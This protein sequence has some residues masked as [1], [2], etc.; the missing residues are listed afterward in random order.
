M[1]RITKK[2]LV[3]LS[4][5]LAALQGLAWAAWGSK[6][7][8]VFAGILLNAVFVSVVALYSSFAKFGAGGTEA[9][10][11]KWAYRQMQ[12]LA[13]LNATLPLRQ[14]LPFL[15]GMAVLPDF[16][17][18]LAGLIREIRPRRILELGSGA[19][20]IIASYVMEELGEGELLSLDHEEPWANQTRDRLTLHGVA[21]R[22]RVEF[23]PLRE[24]AAGGQQMQW[25]GYDRL[26]EF[27]PIDL[28]VVDGPPD[29]TGKM[30]RYPALP[31]IIPM[32]SER[33]AVLIDDFA[34]PD[35]TEMVRL[36]M[37][38]FPGFTLEKLDFEKG[39]ALLRRKAHD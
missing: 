21:A 31:M 16:A 24:I 32:L 7:G 30:A 8:L 5:A 11:R 28:L 2:F 14:P 12:S 19:S 6:G 35:E 4:L 20:T 9:I 39:A 15:G 18:C 37:Q 25:Y 22:T 36:W 3:L 29:W 38:S 13:Y 27:G 34:R 1:R 23:A 33:A 10:A 26:A 17:A